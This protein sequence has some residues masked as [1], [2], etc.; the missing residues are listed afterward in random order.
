MIER[1]G[2]KIVLFSLFC[3]VPLTE[4]ASPLVRNEVLNAL[5]LFVRLNLN[6]FREMAAEFPDGRSS[7]RSSSIKKN[8]KLF[9]SYFIFSILI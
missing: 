3:L 2:R 6:L 7:N 8:L 1:K 9:P 4:D 5:A